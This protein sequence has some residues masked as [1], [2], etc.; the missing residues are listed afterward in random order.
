[1]VDAA[2]AHIVFHSLC[3]KAGGAGC[4]QG[5][6]PFRPGFAALS[7]HMPRFCARI[8]F[9]LKTRNLRQRKT[10]PH[11][12]VHRKCA[13]RSLPGLPAWCRS[14]PKGLDVPA[15]KRGSL[16]NP[17]R[18]KD[19]TQHKAACAHSF[20]QN[21]CKDKADGAVYVFIRYSAWEKRLS[22]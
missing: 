18:I 7:A 6:R 5:R 12:F 9:P 21:V 14:R 8:F 3:A 19:L 1:M 13:E 20:P 22:M 15:R 16:L 11:N 10:L 2:I 17:H 4:R